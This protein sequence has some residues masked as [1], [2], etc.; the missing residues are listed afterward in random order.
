MNMTLKAGILKKLTTKC[1]F[2]ETFED[3]E[4]AE[5]GVLSYSRRKIMH[6][7]ACFVS[8][9]GKTVDVKLVDSKNWGL[10]DD[11]KERF[12]ESFKEMVVWEPSKE[13]T[14][15]DD[16]WVRIGT[17]GIIPVKSL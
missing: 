15:K 8:P 9:A 16:I 5:N 11:E 12:I 1:P 7:R 13:R 14:K 2:S 4:P 3:T 17:R 6:F 10:T